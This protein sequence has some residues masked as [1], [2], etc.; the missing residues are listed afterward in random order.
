MAFN[1]AQFFGPQPV[2]GNIDS[3]TF[4]YVVSAIAPGL[5]QASAKFVF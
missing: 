3:P 1:R 2:D 4:G 5:M